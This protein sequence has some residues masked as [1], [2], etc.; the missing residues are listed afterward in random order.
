[1]SAHDAESITVEL[2]GGLGNQ[3]F[4]YATGLAQAERLGCPLDLDITYF[5]MSDKRT[6]AL[7]S[8]HHSGRSLT[9]TQ[10]PKGKLIAR[11]QNRTGS[12]IRE[13]SYKYDP[14]VAVI[15]VGTRLEGYF[16]SWRY[17]SEI[18]DPL[19]GQIRNLRSP[20]VWYQ[21]MLAE[22]S[23]EAWV[24][25]HIRRGDYTTAQYR[26]TFGP[27]SLQYIARGLDL[28]R[29]VCGPVK[30][31]VFTDDPVNVRRELLA[32]GM[33]G[34][35]E[36][37]IEPPPDADPLE[38]MLLLSRATHLVLSNSS[39]SWWAAFLGDAQDRLVVAPRPWFIGLDHDT[40]DLL[41]PH[42]LTL[43]SRA[44]RSEPSSS[45]SENWTG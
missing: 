15:G 12:T 8:F 45:P 17:F 41:L 44:L 24:G 6:L 3:L 32:A 35:A 9:F 31:V 27:V 2:I 16:Q 33:G 40:R 22:L 7:E 26:D 13:A 14:R 5:E 21:K 28:V 37:V 4:Q 38:S 10:K 36:N 29:R 25:V 20:S 1:M 30:T 23:E 42:W 19:R 39:F 43:E 18:A 11:L 34:L